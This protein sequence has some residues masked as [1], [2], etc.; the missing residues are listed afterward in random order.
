MA[1][2]SEV[3]ATLN[4]TCLIYK[5]VGSGGLFPKAH[6]ATRSSINSLTSVSLDQP[7][8]GS[9]KMEKWMDHIHGGLVCE[10]SFLFY[11][12]KSVIY[13]YAAEKA[14]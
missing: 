12:R 4:E 10:T 5:G 1:G 7:L 8:H 2:T 13:I 3:Y 9:R 6:K 11:H 14:V